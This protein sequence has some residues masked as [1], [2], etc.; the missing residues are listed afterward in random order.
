MQHE[1]SLAGQPEIRNDGLHF[2]SF[3]PYA[4]QIGDDVIE[5]ARYAGAG[6]Y[7]IGVV[8]FEKRF[9]PFH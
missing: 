1:A 6:A 5:G 9:Y 2:I 3:R 8:E 4:L 7:L